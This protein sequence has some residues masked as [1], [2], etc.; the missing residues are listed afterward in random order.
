M[1]V[2]FIQDTTLQKITDAIRKKTGSS[3][4]IAVSQIEEEIE[5]LS[6]SDFPNYYGAYEIV[7]LAE[8]VTL[9]TAN[10]V[11]VKDLQIAAIPYYEVSNATGT[12]VYIG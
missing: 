7:P 11:L 2:F 8:A 10:K 3:E 4:K 5:K 12:T 1:A 6:S 9:P